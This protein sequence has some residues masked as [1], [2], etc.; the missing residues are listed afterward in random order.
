MKPVLFVYLNVYEGVDEV[1]V[2]IGGP[3][4]NEMKLEDFGKLFADAL[5]TLKKDRFD[6]MDKECQ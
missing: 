5:K 6:S 2:T 4:H 1:G 3:N